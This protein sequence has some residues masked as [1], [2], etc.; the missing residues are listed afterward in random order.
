MRERDLCL[1]HAFGHPQVNRALAVSELADKY[2]AMGV[3]DTTN[4]GVVVR[5]AKQLATLAPFSDEIFCPVYRP[6]NTDSE[7]ERKYCVGFSIPVNTPGLKFICRQ[8]HDLGESLYDYPL[9]GRYD[10]MDAL[11]VFED[12]LIPWDR[13]FQF[14]DM[15][16]ANLALQAVPMWRQYMQQVAVKNIAKLE[17]ILGITHR[18]A[19]GIGID[20][21][22][23]VQEKIA[24]VV[25]ILETVRSYM[26]AAE[27]DAAFHEVNGLNGETIEGE[28]IWPAPE[29]WI[30]MRIWY[31]DAYVRGY[32][33]SRAVGGGRPD[34]DAHRTGRPRRVGG[35]D[36][37]ILQR[38]QPGCYGKDRS[39]SIGLGPDG[40]AVRV[41]ANPVRE[42]LQRRRS[43]VAAAPVRHLRLHQGHQG[44]GH[45]SS[46]R[47]VEG[48][49]PPYCSS[50]GAGVLRPTTTNNGSPGGLCSGLTKPEWKSWS[51]PA[52]RM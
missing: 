9:S 24:E 37:Q 25:D 46:Q 13:V 36:R 28:G 47:P 27:A 19:L 7:D 11:A 21:F 6:L 23:H 22:S 20:V 44:S 8:S 42:I 51:P 1:T 45:F 34:A 12:V 38:R 26:R 15:E 5:G 4:D 3:V 32:L 30:A 17:F 29:P 49:A 52:A 48:A 2:T 18:I 31:P 39:I 33:D 35:G 41:Q 10:E 40:H 43:P 16:L 14:E 50:Y